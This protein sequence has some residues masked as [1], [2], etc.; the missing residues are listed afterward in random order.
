[1][2]PLFLVTDTFPFGTGETFLETE[3][4]YLAREFA[5]TLIPRVVAGPPRELPP[6]VALDT[7]YAEAAGGGWR[8]L[9]AAIARTPTSPRFYQELL[10]HPSILAHPRALGRCVKYLD[11][12]ITFEGWLAERLRG[13]PDALLYTYWVRPQTMAGLRLKRGRPGLRVVSRVHR[14]DLY[15]EEFAGRYLPFRRESFAGLDRL[16]PISEHGRR[17]AL[18][19]F[20]GLDARTELQRLGVVVPPWRC[21]PSADG[22][23]RLVS[24]SY[25]VPTKRVDLLVDGLARLAASHPERRF[26]WH[27]LGDGPQRAAIEEKAAAIAPPNLA[28]RFHGQKTNAQIFA[29]YQAHPVDCFLNTSSSE[30]I[31]VAIMEALSCSVPVVATDVGGTS[32]IVDEAN[33]VLLS[34]SPDAGE[35]A[36]A[37]GRV[38][39]APPG[40]RRHAARETVTARFDAETNYP[41]FCAA[42]TA[43]FD[44]PHAI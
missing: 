11:E 39:Q 36:A 31:P 25:L 35:I 38:I 30:G 16:Y 23:S 33:G 6:G 8:R 27:H 19:L 24:C 26:E 29:Y 17:Y 7:G 10:A 22:V 43:L 3:L 37:V 41:R 42:L 13:L 15:L 14:N 2:K 4:R 40:A 5:V 18:A 32:E 20:P 28:C 1:M 21:G 44:D 12:A 34:A 9:V